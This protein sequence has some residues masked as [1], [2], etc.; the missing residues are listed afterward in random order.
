MVAEEILLWKRL[1][2][3][4]TNAKIIR[5]YLKGYG[6]FILD[7]FIR[8]ELVS[9]DQTLPRHFFQNVVFIFVVCC[10]QFLQ[11]VINNVGVYVNVGV[12]VAVEYFAG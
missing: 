6:V 10:R 9:V 8:P 2:K 12:S 1:W 4:N 7:L 5:F 11:N 3:F